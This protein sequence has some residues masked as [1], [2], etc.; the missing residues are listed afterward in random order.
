MR[1][2][3]SPPH[4]PRPSRGSRTAPPSSPTAAVPATST[5]I[6]RSQ[7]LQRVCPDRIIESRMRHSIAE[8][9]LYR[10]ALILLAALGAHGAF[11]QL[12]IRGPA[13]IVNVIEVN[14]HEDQVDLTMVFNCSMR[15]VTSLPASEGRQVHIQLAPMP[16]CGVGPLSRSE[17]HTS[18]LQSPCN[19]VCRLLLEKKKA[20]QPQRIPTSFFS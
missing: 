4:T 19:L 6:R 15:F 3:S 8:R 5:A 17:E 11:A 9:R 16:D 18:E 7:P 10:L 12:P 2:T 20:R 1:R 13:R 14:D